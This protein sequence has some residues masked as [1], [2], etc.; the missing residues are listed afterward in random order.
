MT[1]VLAI[2][3]ICAL[4]GL[5]YWAHRTM[6]MRWMAERYAVRTRMT[7][8]EAQAYAPICFDQAIEWDLLPFWPDKTWTREGAYALVDEELENWE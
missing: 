1:Y 8:A 3:C 5:Y 7:F 6:M 4:A 2:L